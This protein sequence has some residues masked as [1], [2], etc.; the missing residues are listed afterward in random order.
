MSAPQVALST[1]IGELTLNANEEFGV[2]FFQRFKRF[3]GPVGSEGGAG[4][5]SRNGGT[6][7]DAFRSF[8]NFAAAATAATTGGTSVLINAGF[9]L[10][11]IVKALS[12][13]G[14]FK[15]ISR[16]TVFTSNNKKAIIASG[17]EIPVPVSTDLGWQYH[18]RRFVTAIEYPV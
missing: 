18:N 7:A 12:S 1:V 17:Q 13:T 15:T 14:R 10:S 3:E 5:I 9:G 8:D 6:A 11:T 16:P 4:G 2:D